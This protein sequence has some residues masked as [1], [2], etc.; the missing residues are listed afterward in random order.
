M[1]GSLGEYLRNAHQSDCAVP[2]LLKK[3]WTYQMFAGLAH[4]H[5]LAI[6]HR[7]IK[8]DNCLVDP[9][10][11]ELKIADFGSAKYIGKDSENAW[12]IGSRA[13]RAPELLLGCTSYNSKVDIW[14]AGCVIAEIWL[15]A[16]PMFQG[17]SNHEQLVQIVQI[18][19]K[20]TNEDVHA[21][22]HTMPY[23]DVD[24]ICS[25]DLA[26]PLEVPPALLKLLK[27]IFQYDPAERPTARQCMGSPYFD[28][29]F[30]SD[31]KLPNGNPIPVLPRCH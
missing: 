10:T 25:V 31:V 18:L 24:Q 5:S 13:Y 26:L 16:L 22:T 12:Y 14:A 17:S 21:F 15:D 2:Q 23:P 4:I 6:C 1:P 27:S 19:G 28:E 8:P 7:D 3:L 29:L 9:W 11:G 30:S 20:P